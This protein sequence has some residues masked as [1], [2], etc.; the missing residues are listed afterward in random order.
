MLRHSPRRDKPD[1][2]VARSPRIGVGMASLTWPARPSQP[3]TAVEIA[4]NAGTQ[5]AD[6]SLTAGLNR[7]RSLF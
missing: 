4:G 2:A 1:G 6:H 5:G 3:P 7:A